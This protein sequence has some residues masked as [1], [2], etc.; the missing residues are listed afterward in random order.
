MVIEAGIF[1]DPGRRAED[2]RG[3]LAVRDQGRRPDRDPRAVQDGLRL[4]YH[5]AASVGELEV[6]VLA[7]ELH[8]GLQ[9]E[10]R[11]DEIDARREDHHVAVSTL[12][13]GCPELSQVPDLYRSTAGQ[14]RAREDGD[15]RR[16]GRVGPRAS[17]PGERDGGR[18]GEQFAVLDAHFFQSPKSDPGTPSP[19]DPADRTGTPRTMRHRRAI[20]LKKT[21]SAGQRRYAGESETAGGYDPFGSRGGPAARAAASSFRHFAAS[22]GLPQAS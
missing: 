20:S 18:H 22:S 13:N 21:P 2:P 1:D 7:Q 6:A 11:I 15:G 8:A 4:R 3:G 14:R 12:I 16:R 17:E 19:N 10:R 9:L 5:L